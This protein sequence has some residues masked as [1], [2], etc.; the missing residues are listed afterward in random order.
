MKGIHSHWARQYRPLMTQGVTRGLLRAAAVGLLASGT[1][2]VDRKYI[3]LS[4]VFIK[5]CEFLQDL[6]GGLGPDKRWKRH[7]FAALGLL[8][9]LMGTAQPSRADDDEAGEIAFASDRAGNMDIWVMN[10]DGTNPVQLTNDPLPE[11]FPAWSPDGTKIAFVRGARMSGEQE[12]WVMK[13]D[14]T[15]QR[16]LTFNREDDIM[17]TWSPDGRK[18]AFVRFLLGDPPNGE[19]YVMNA[20]GKGE[21]N[22]TNNPAP[23]EFKPDWS[24]DGKQI[25]F[26]SDRDLSSDPEECGAAVHTMRPN[27]KYLRR[28]T[29]VPQQAF[30]PAWSPDGEDLVFSDNACRGESDLF[31]M[32]ADGTGF[33]QLFETLENEAHATW[34]P[35]GQRIAF[36]R[37]VLDDQGFVPGSGEIYVIGKDG[38]GLTNLTNYPGADDQHPDWAPEQDEE[39][40]GD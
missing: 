35:D 6:V 38:E 18:I 33:M 3:Q 9:V 20:N 25:A 40:D 11:V 31:V 34:S 28:L 21:R 24:P 16:Q 13:A 37:V 4:S 23:F 10:A 29:D 19:V 26:D 39:Q 17:P 15:R 22:L 30:S 8:A 27:G 1:S 14:G 32:K 36:G 7:A 5:G 12:I 2:V